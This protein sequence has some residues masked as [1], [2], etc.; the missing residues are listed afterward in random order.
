[1][2]PVQIGLQVYQLQYGGSRVNCMKIMNPCSN[3][4]TV[5]END[6][7]LRLPK[8]NNLVNSQC[9]QIR[10]VLLFHNLLLLPVT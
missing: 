1:M 9:Q 4:Q 10:L 6:Q 2:F 3:D 8:T 5:K 7:S